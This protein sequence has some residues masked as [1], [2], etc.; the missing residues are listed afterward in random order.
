VQAHFYPTFSIALLV[1]ALQF[2]IFGKHVDV[3]L[4]LWA[5]GTALTFLFS[6]AIL[7]VVFNGTAVTADHV[8]PGMYIP[9]V[10]LV[11]V[12]LAGASLANAFG[13][14]WQPFLLMVNWAALGAGFFLYLALTAVTLSR[15]MLQPR[16][17]GPLTVTLWVNLAPPSVLALSLTNIATV[18]PGV[19]TSGALNAIA[20]MLWGF[21]AW[22]LVMSAILTLCARRRDELP[23]ALAW[24]AFTFPLGAF[25]AASHRLGGGLNLYPVYYIGFAALVLL[26]FLW[27]LTLVMTVRAV[28]RGEL[29]RGA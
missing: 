14:E 16:L 18:T 13:A 29:L 4:A 11:V 24:W 3:A 9:P 23:F 20:L 28:A 15:L 2:L 21:A 6:F 25:V 17:P 8:N 10:G 26:A 7:A 1:L 5:A 27:A 22:W 19:G 12:P